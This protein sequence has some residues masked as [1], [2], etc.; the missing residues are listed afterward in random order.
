MGARL[1][2]ALSPADPRVALREAAARRGD[3][4]AA[5]SRMIDRPPGYLARFVNQGRPAALSED[6]HRRLSDHLDAGELGLGIRDI[7]VRHG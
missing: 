4:L 6:Q 1:C 2:L 7:W 5:L 3:S